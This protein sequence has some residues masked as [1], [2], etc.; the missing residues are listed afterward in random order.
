[1]HVCARTRVI[2]KEKPKATTYV[3]LLDVDRERKRPSRLIYL[4]KRK[5]VILYKNNY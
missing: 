1:M 2:N 3:G 5:F 4:W